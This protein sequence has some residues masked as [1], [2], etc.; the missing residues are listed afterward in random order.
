LKLRS[1]LKTTGGK[2]LHVVV[3]VARKWSWDEHKAIAHGIVSE[4]AGSDPSAYLTKMS[5]QARKGKIFLDY[6]RN[7]RGATAVAPYSTRAR[8]GAL[9]ATPITWQELEDGVKPTDFDIPRVVNRLQIEQVD[10]WA[11]FFK[12]RQ[13]LTA[14]QLRQ[15]TK[16]R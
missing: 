2:G 13:G 1:F 7:G 3:P 8:E 11:D 15:L 10:P 5:K 4:L 12:L 14:S 9:V 6:L 16:P